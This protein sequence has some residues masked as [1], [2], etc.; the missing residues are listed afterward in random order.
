MSESKKTEQ[1]DLIEGKAVKILVNIS[2]RKEVIDQYNSPFDIIMR[3]SKTTAEGA[4]EKESEIRTSTKDGKGPKV[5]DQFKKVFIH[6]KIRAL[7]EAKLDNKNSE[8]VRT[9]FYE[10]FWDDESLPSGY[11]IT[12]VE[13]EILTI[14]TSKFAIRLNKDSWEKKSLKWRETL[15]PKPPTS[16]AKKRKR[17]EAMGEVKAFVQSRMKLLTGATWSANESNEHY[18][19]L[20]H[21]ILEKYLSPISHDNR[22]QITLEDFNKITEDVEETPKDDEDQVDAD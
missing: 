6:N 4:V 10:V 5:A 21:E 12:P 22:D 19:A 14:S 11:N 18:T 9:V 16:D 7:M 2:E 20:L 8:R 17:N 1:V 13:K 15:Y 3:M